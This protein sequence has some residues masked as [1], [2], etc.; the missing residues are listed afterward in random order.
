MVNNA[1]LATSWFFSLLLVRCVVC[2]TVSSIVVSLAT[3]YL[4]NRDLDLLTSYPGLD[5]A[6]VGWPR[7]VLRDTN[8]DR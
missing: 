3:A 7:S 2:R 1:T 5:L 8:S 6:F 4:Q